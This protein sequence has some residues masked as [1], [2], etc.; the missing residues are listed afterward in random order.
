MTYTKTEVNNR[1]EVSSIVTVIHKEISDKV[2]RGESHDFPEIYY[3]EK[4]NAYLCVDGKECDL[5]KGQM[6]I[7]APD[8]FHQSNPTR[9]A[10]KRKIGI[11]SFETSIP[12][13]TALY[14][15][16]ITL[17]KNQQ[18]MLTQL[19]SDGMGIFE[20]NRSGGKGMEIKKGTNP[21]LIQALK[22]KLELFL[23]E[24]YISEGITDNPKNI[25]MAELTKFMLK[26]LDKTLTL[27]IISKEMAISNSVLR[28]LTKEIHGMGPISYFSTLKIQ[29]AINMIN[30]GNLNMTEISEKLGYC[31]VHHFSRKFKTHT[32]KTPTEYKNG[33]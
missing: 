25:M 11:I 7:Y 30:Q 23:T 26:N 8:A 22:N 14:N 12:L 16:V 28:R 24:L 33:L 32:G 1:I 17:S 2:S 27:E 21:Y 13:P 10:G 4:G 5:S 15:R 20:K 29:E 19:I 6:V 18:R 3:V 31:S 9:S